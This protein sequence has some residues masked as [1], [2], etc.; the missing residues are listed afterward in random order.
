MSKDQ[1]PETPQ[2][3]VN[4][5]V[6]VKVICPVCE[7]ESTQVYVK[8]KLYQPIDIEKD[9]HVLTYRWTNEEFSAIKPE[10]FFIWHCPHCHF[11][12]ENQVFRGNI[13]T[14]WKGKLEL[15]SFKL[16]KESEKS[17]SLFSKIG[18][19][20]TALSEIPISNGAAI[21]THLLACYVQ[22]GFLSPNN[23]M[24]GKLAK[25]FLRLAWLYRERKALNATSTDIP[26]GYLSLEDFLKVQQQSWEGLPIT[27]EEAIK[28]SIEQYTIV[29][30][31]AGKEDNTKKEITL[32]FLLLNLNLKLGEMDTAFTYVR[33]IFSTAMKT[34]QAYKNTLDKGMQTGKISTQQIEQFKGLITW[35]S[36]VIEEASATGD[37]INEEIF[38]IEYE[39]A[40]D[41]ALKVAPMLPKKV[42]EA[43]RK[44]EF[45]EITCR[46]VASICK[47][48][49]G[50]KVLQYL[51]TLEEL[52]GA[53]T[54]SDSAEG[55][56]NEDTEAQGEQDAGE[57]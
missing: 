4:P 31:H 18:K 27:E 37:E 40:R 45:H 49:K 8:S 36:N 30:D 25:F 38:W 17:E 7:Q 6:E 15:M 35:L 5:Y 55:E 54:E 10:N 13:D 47:P 44:A 3:R 24:P 53:E 34:R 50:V 32:M 43:L 23:R 9:H 26:D 56:Q 12:D 33:S 42:L 21:L 52:K 46:K 48:P 28:K 2:R 14:I 22:E 19:Q 41:A 1:Q 39:P 20:A 51:P 29:L 16:I 57:Q 11:S